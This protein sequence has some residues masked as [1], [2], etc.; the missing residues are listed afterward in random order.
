[1]RTPDDISARLE[2]L[3]R[4]YEESRHDLGHRAATLLA[5][6]ELCHA[7]SRSLPEW[8]YEAVHNQL[9]HAGHPVVWTQD[10]KDLVRWAVVCRLLDQGVAWDK[11]FDIAA[12]KL[13]GHPAGAGAQMLRKS[14][15]TL[16]RELPPEKR[17]QRK[18]SKV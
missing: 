17:R 15:F 18:P 1:M 16:Q 5:A 2:A 10:G 11:V 8:L 3:R 12:E 13:E 9:E 14:F 4:E 6:F 7:A